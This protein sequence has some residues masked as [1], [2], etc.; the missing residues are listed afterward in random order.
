MLPHL[1]SAVLNS[2]PGLRH[3][4]FTRQGGASEGIFA[5]LNCGL[6]SADA[7][8]AVIENRARAATH[9]GVAPW[10]LLTVYQ[11]HSPNCV[12]V[13]APWVE[14]QAPEADAMVTREPGIA[15]GILAAD[16]APILLADKSAGVIGA[17]HA[18]WKGAIGGVIE[19]TLAAMESLGARRS[20]IVAA[21]GPC[22]GPRSYEVGSEFEARFRA[23][24]PGYG[25]F[26]GMAARP[27]HFMFDL[28]GFV[29]ARVRASGAV[30]VDPS[31]GDTYTQDQD[32]FSYR[33]AT[34]RGEPDYG[35][36]L[37][38]IVLA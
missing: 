12:T 28:P 20:Q 35:R 38:A 25:S 4:F 32:F 16:C 14:G 34:H 19:S 2:V 30:L 7:R 27:G 5:S 26:F 31:P 36:N 6:G 21:V 1:E 13:D 10:Q 37:S 23:A 24:D 22:I 11:C 17:A 29:A 9:L 3:A 18:G 15:L 8:T 33:R